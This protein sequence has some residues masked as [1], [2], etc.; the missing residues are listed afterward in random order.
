MVV[1]GYGRL[2]RS[3]DDEEEELAEEDGA[4]PIK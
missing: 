1:L 4:C 2:S 3:L